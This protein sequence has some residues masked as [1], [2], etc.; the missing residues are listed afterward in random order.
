MFAR[1]A[2]AL[3][4]AALPT[5]LLAGCPTTPQ[6]GVTDA[7]QTPE[8]ISKPDEL[9]QQQV[10]DALSM[11]STSAP[12]G[13]SS[14][15]ATFP[16]AMIDAIEAPA[17][18]ASEFNAVGFDAIEISE[19]E[20][21]ADVAT[22]RGGRRPFRHGGLAGRFL[23]DRPGGSSN[24]SA[25]QFRG[26]WFNAAGEVIAHLNGVY[27]PLRPDELPPGIVGGGLFEG[28]LMS[29]EGRPEGVL[30]GHYG[31]G[32]NSRGAF[33]GRW[34][35][36]EGHMIGALRGFWR[37]VPESGGG[38]FAGRWGA[39]RICDEADSLIDDPSIDEQG[40][41][42]LALNALLQPADAAG[43]I[44]LEVSPQIDE[45]SDMRLLPEGSTAPC[46]EPGTPHGFLLGR[47]W[48]LRP[49]PDQ[50]RRPRGGFAGDW[51]G[52]DRELS[53]RVIG[54]WIARATDGD[55]GGVPLMSDDDAATAGAGLFAP[56]GAGL[57]PSDDGI[58]GLGASPA[59]GPQ[60]GRVL[61]HFQGVIVGGDEQVRGYVSGAFG[62]SAHGAQVFRGQFLNADERPLGHI[63]GRWAQNPNRPGGPIF[64]VWIADDAG[65]G[66]PRI[67]GSGD[68][69]A[70][71]P[72]EAALAP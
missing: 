31:H 10:F 40:L 6:A 19:E 14:A 69:A 50:P 51:V 72:Q 18:S 63:R 36:V 55:D 26:E 61:G 37:D 29:V 15:S 39:Y 58:D 23:N 57:T 16:D 45:Q 59:D 44:T 65:A 33:V 70:A 7:T 2:C 5:L 67:E 42:A 30:R 49:D 34:L 43:A 71:A 56:A 48:P 52:A 53:A 27:Q 62:V 13:A 3:L 38:V 24:N 47:H 12:S 22:S 35:D 9:N 4:G 68:D 20:I 28:R 66:D 1:L 17:Q 21:A 46:V 25:G 64:G 11:L 32:R 54:R 8:A 60:R 41:D